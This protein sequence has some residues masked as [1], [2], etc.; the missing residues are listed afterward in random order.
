M[1]I[2]ADDTTILHHVGLKDVDHTQDELNNLLL[3][4]VDNKMFINEKKTHIMDISLQRNVISA[5]L[6][7][8]QHQIT[9]EDEI[10]ILGMY[11]TRDLKIDKHVFYIYR[12]CCSGM[13]AIKKLRDYNVPNDIIW[14]AYLAIV[15]SHI[16]YAWPA[17]CDCQNRLMTKFIR[18]ETQ[19]IRICKKKCVNMLVNR[20]DNICLRL[21]KKISRHSDHP[22]RVLFNERK[23]STHDLRQWHSLTPIN[24]KSTKL[25][26]SFAKY[27]KY[28]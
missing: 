20:L 8:G 17:I 28:S 4:S 13:F 15:F 24:Y 26:K 2:Y 25:M 9:S 23:N 3:W 27:Y 16:A 7:I 6:Y 11:L 12:K 21:M 5:P 22:L 14:K 19:A 10:K 1:V 18:L